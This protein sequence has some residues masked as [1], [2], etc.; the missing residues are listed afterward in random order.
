MDV[1]GKP[2]RLFFS[3]LAQFATSPDEAADLHAMGEGKGEQYD[4]FVRHT[5]SL[6]DTLLLFPSARPPL[7]Y[8]LD[9]IPTI[10]PRAY[11]ICSTPRVRL[12]R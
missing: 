11:S 12:T 3:H 2:P 9:M 1:F 8:L 6:A 7:P 5:R 4:D 10:K